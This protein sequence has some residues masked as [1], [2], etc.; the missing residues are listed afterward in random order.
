MQ[1]EDYLTVRLE[2]AFLANE[3]LGFLFSKK[4]G[5]KLLNDPYKTAQFP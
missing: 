1:S 5:H 2:A 3:S 4:K